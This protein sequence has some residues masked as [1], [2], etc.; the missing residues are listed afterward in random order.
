M[1]MAPSANPPMNM[2][3]KNRKQPSVPSSSGTATQGSG[4]TSEGAEG[5]KNLWVR[6]GYHQKRTAMP[7]TIAAWNVSTLL[8]RKNTNWPERRSTLVTRELQRYKIDITALSETRFPDTGQLREIGSGYTIFWSGRKTERMAGGGFA[9][10]TTLVSQLESQPQSINDRIVTMRIPMPGKAYATLI[11][12]YAPTMTNKDE[13]KGALYQQLDNV[14]CSIPTEDQLIIMDD[15]NARIG[16]DSFAWPGIIGPRGVRHKNSNGRLLLSLWSQHNLAVTNT[17][18]KLIDAYKKTWMYPRSKHWHQ[19]D[20]TICR[21]RDLCD[22]RVTRAMRGAEFSTDHLLLR[23]KVNLQ[24]RKK[25]RLQGK[26]PPKKLD[27]NKLEN[28][29]TTAALQKELSVHLEKVDFT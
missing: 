16:A 3:Y 17:F 15:M 24:V 27:L 21:K 1:C 11:S 28:P 23:S 9:I 14:M 19:I 2:M 29:D 8:D 6:T 13:I 4:Q 22:F 5:A 18:L 10:K 26:R 25:R 12:A 7:L 20:F